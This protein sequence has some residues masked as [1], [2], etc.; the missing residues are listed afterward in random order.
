MMRSKNK[1]KYRTNYE[2]ILTKNRNSN[3][4]GQ[5]FAFRH[6]N[7]EGCV[8]ERLQNMDTRISHLDASFRIISYLGLDYFDPIMASV[9]Y[10]HQ[11][12]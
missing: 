7:Q 6:Q 2:N 12:A 5:T 1:K 3:I 9:T 8:Y 4:V 10:R 11:T